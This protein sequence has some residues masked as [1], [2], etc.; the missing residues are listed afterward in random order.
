MDHLVMSTSSLPLWHWKSVFAMTGVFYWQNSVS[1]CLASF[2]APSPNMPVTPG[3]S[4]SYFCV[5]FPYDE[6]DIFFG[7]QFQKGL[8]VFAEPFN[9]S[10]FSITGWHID[11]D[12]CDIEW[13]SL[14][15]DRVHSVVLKMA[16]KYCISDS[17][18]YYEGYS[19]SSKGFFPT[20][21]DI[22]VI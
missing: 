10:F 8:Q 12:Y 3:V 22:T 9:F 19:I 1:L 14:E 6:K 20:V 4:T 16:P 17:L 13:F 11:L 2:C 21:V 15:M 5:P 18:V 7:C